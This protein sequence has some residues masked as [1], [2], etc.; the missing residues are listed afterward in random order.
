MRSF[1]KLAVKLAVTVSAVVCAAA[2]GVLGSSAFDGSSYISAYEQEPSSGCFNAAFCGNY[3]VNVSE[4]VARINEIRLEACNEGV[5][6]PRNS[7]RQLT[8]Q[9]YVP[10]KWSYDLEQKARLRAAEATYYYSHDRPNGR[11]CWTADAGVSIWSSSEVIAFMN[12]IDMVTGLNMFY[13]EKRAWVNKTSGA[14]TGHYT[15]MIDPDNTYFGLG[16]FINNN[17]YSWDAVCGRFGYDEGSSGKAGAGKDN[18]YVPV[19]VKNNELTD[20]ELK[21]V[22][23]SETLCLGDTAEYELR[24]TLTSSDTTLRDVLLVG[25]TWKSSNKSVVT[26]NKYGR[27]TAKGYGTATV[28]ASCAGRKLTAEVKVVRSINDCDV[29]IPYSSY[30]Y[31]GRSVKPNVTVMS[32]DTKLVKGTDYTV[33]YSNNLNA[34]TAA[35]TVKGKG[36]VV[37]SKKITFTIEPLTIG[38]SYCDLSTRYSAY[39]Y[40]GKQVKPAV[41]FNFRDGVAIP[42]S[43]YKVTYSSNINVG[44]AK[45]KVEPANSNIKGTW[46]KTFYI[47]PAVQ[48]ITKVSSSGGKFRVWWK[49][50]PQATGYQVLYS[51]DKSFKNGVRST[52]TYDNTVTSKTISKGLVPGETWYVKVRSFLEVDGV[53]CGNYSE[54]KTITIQ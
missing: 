46:T 27:V 42:A 47:K 12:N 43:D 51:K 18:C 1:G 52:A 3:T 8:P 30:V 7:S 32:G 39:S 45:V 17:S 33:S 40:T 11:S 31:R 44:A 9:D 4:A 22:N 6:D 5:W 53:R 26:V 35:I 49:N 34:G 28:T 20:A 54:V 13:Q 48:T 19:E 14:V 15:S 10:I 38:S 21:L 29:T 36:N 37:G 41:T 24:G 25:T 23:G 50:D 2:A 16:C